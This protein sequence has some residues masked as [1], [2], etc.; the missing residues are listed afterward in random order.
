[1]GVLAYRLYLIV[2]DLHFSMRT[3][4]CIAAMVLVIAIVYWPIDW[5]FRESLIWNTL[6]YVLIAVGIPFLFKLTK[7]NPLDANIGEL[8]YPIYMCHLLVMA[9]V[10]W[11]PLNNI[12]IW[13]RHI[14]TI[15]LVIIAAFLLDRLLVLPIDRLRLKF[16]AKP[17]IDSSLLEQDARSASAVRR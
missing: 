2:P 6:P 16:G 13:P 4:A 12:P 10:Q 5:V 15:I 11:S 7:D 1:L 8:S 3:Q 14:F 17:R 9:L